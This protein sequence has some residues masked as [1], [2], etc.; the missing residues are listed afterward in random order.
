[1]VRE[2]KRYC[3][4]V[5]T[6]YKEW[7]HTSTDQWFFPQVEYERWAFVM[8]FCVNL[9]KHESTQN[10]IKQDKFSKR[11][12]AGPKNNRAVNEYEEEWTTGYQVCISAEWKQPRNRLCPSG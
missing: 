5:L 11:K 10:S 8:E 12:N 4:D 7:H 6:S 2:N 1:M 9:W 3:Y